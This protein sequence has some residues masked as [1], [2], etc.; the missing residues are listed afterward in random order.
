[1]SNRFASYQNSSRLSLSAGEQIETAEQELLTSASA[2]PR[3]TLKKAGLLLLLAVAGL[4]L[5]EGLSAKKKKSSALAKSRAAPVYRPSYQFL[6]QTPW[7]IIVRIIPAGIETYSRRT[8]SVEHPA[9]WIAAGAKWQYEPHLHCRVASLEIVF[10]EYWRNGEPAPDNGPGGE[11]RTF[12]WR[13]VAPP[14]MFDPYE[15]FIISGTSGRTTGYNVEQRTGEAA[16][17]P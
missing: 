16:Q 7:T 1:M 15:V 12:E 17:L 13:W 10:L 9:V 5:W 4:V 14:L 11:R 8:C 2:A 6:N 3:P